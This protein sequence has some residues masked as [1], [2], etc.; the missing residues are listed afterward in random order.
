MHKYPFFYSFTSYNVN[1]GEPKETL[2]E[3]CMHFRYRVIPLHFNK[4]GT[5]LCCCVHFMQLE[6][7]CGSGQA[8]VSLVLTIGFP[9]H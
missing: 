8:Q 6:I 1:G 3:S 9:F 7:V 5:F 4:T 2:L